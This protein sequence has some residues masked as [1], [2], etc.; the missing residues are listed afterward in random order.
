M[1]YSVINTL[2]KSSLEYNP[3]FPKTLE[4]R[5]KIFGIQRNQQ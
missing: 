3:N 1:V 2:D 5:I 4:F